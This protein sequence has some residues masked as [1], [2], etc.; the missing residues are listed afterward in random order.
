LKILSAMAANQKV[1]VV[2]ANRHP[3]NF[4][5]KQPR[6]LSQNSANHG[7]VFEQRTRALREI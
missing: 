3:I 5:L 1:Q 4:D 2:P 7:L 6:R